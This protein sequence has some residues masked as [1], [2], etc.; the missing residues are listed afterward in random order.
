MQPEKAKF[1]K[2][3]SFFDR[4]LLIDLLEYAK[5][6]YRSPELV[7]TTN[8]H[9][10]HH[11]VQDSTPVLIHRIPKDNKKN[12]VKRIKDVVSSKTGIEDIDNIMLY[13]WTRFSYIPWHHDAHVE[14]AITVYL[15]E[16]WQPDHGGYFLYDY[17]RD[18]NI[19]GVVPELN[20]ALL[21]R[22]GLWHCTTPVNWNGVVRVTCQIFERKK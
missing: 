11:V 18:G 19:R 17:N 2:F 16:N 12:L 13:Y 6:T 21:Q 8:S 3:T 14:S 10:G 9:W 5:Q 4:E 20:V 22:N 7:F 15:N 1:E